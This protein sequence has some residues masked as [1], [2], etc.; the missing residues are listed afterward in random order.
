M[1]AAV[2]DPGA[3]WQDKR[4]MGVRPVFADD[5]TTGFSVASKA[6]AEERMEGFLGFPSQTRRRGFSAAD[7]RRRA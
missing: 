3:E 5:S 2:G 6:G 7:Y 4:T 1:M